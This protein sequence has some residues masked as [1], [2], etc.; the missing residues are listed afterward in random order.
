MSVDWPRSAGLYDGE[1]CSVSGETN[2][3]AMLATLAP[4]ML[5]PEFV[6]ASFETSGY[7]DHAEL[8][9]IG[10]FAEREGLT[11]IVPRHRADQFGVAYESVF[12]C[13]SLKLHSSLDAVGLTATFSQQ[14][15]AHGISANVIAGYY[16][17]HIFV[18]AERAD[19][20]LEAIRALS[21]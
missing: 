19:D 3:A 21:T 5:E 13:I 16:H 8:E 17:D 10:M 1:K 7:G 9:P 18:Q 14:L 20:A 2:L 12:R 15:T 4:E 6:F 11:L